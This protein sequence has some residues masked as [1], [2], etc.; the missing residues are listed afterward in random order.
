MSGL[1]FAFGIIVLGMLFATIRSIAY[2]ITGRSPVKR[3]VLAVELQAAQDK[4]RSLESELLGARLQNDQLQRQVEW[5]AKLL[6]TQDRL[7]A[8]L[9]RPAAR[10]T[11]TT[12]G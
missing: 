7:V 9:S 3:K 11:V 12:H 4:I 1:E 5:H 10:D 2:A 8:Q 6:E